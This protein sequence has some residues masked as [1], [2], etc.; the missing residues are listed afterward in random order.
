[1]WKRYPN[2]KPA[3][4][5]L[6]AVANEL[7]AWDVILAKWLGDR[8]VECN[9][10]VATLGFPLAVTHFIELPW[11]NNK[12]GQVNDCY[13]TNDEWVHNL[14]ETMKEDDDL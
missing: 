11:L 14:R 6:Y 13:I 4:N 7:C 10:R 8:W 9:S 2:S 5:F 1:M 12:T 3:E